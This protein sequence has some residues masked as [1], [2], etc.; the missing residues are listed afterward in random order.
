M[1]TDIDSE[2][3]TKDPKVKG[4]D[5]QKTPNSLG[6]KESPN[7]A[8]SGRTISDTKISDT[9][10]N[11]SD[12]PRNTLYNLFFSDIPKDCTIYDQENLRNKNMTR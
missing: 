12:A 7:K 8:G 11:G 5:E 10:W 6:V 9:S 3:L 1:K 2:S 4:S